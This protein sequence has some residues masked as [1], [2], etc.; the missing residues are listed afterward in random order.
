MQEIEE[1]QSNHLLEFFDETKS[2]NH[3]AI[4][5][6]MLDTLKKEEFFL[7]GTGGVVSDG[8]LSPPNDSPMIS[9]MK[10]EKNTE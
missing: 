7:T 9:Q 4:Q 10:D 5:N 8:Q 3:K 2:K 1:E 6:D